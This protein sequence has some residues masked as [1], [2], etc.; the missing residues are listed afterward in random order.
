MSSENINAK[1][2]PNPFKDVFNLDYTTTID[3]DIRIEIYD[4]SGKKISSIHKPN[5]SAGNY[6]ETINSTEIGNQLAMF[7]IRIIAG[8]EVISKTVISGE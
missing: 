8:S 2:Y 1:I 5:Q 4:N 6:T 3:S 7:H